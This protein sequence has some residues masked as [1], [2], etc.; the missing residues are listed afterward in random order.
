M[1]NYDNTDRGQIWPNRDKKT[2]KHPDFTGSLN[3]GGVEYWVSAWRKKPDANPKAPSLTFA[4]KPK[5]EAHQQ[6]M[7]QA[8]QSAP[9]P[10]QQAPSGSNHGGKVAADFDS[11]DI[12]F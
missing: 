8:R 12:P 1:S 4:V 10:Q 2:D 6:G 7:Q 9:P 11:D 3:I 5:D